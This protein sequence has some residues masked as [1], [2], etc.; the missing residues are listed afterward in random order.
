[1]TV[2]ELYELA[3]ERDCEDAEIQT[4]GEDGLIT[5]EMEDI[6]VYYDAIII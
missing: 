2:R 6:D 3:K 4:R 1:M 5:I